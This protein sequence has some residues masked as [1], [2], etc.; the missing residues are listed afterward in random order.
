MAKAQPN[1]QA[2]AGERKLRKVTT[3]DNRQQA[4]E[5]VKVDEMRRDVACLACDKQSCLE[6]QTL[7]ADEPWRK[8]WQRKPKRLQRHLTI[9]SDFPSFTGRIH[10]WQ[11]G[12]TFDQIVA[13][14]AE[15]SHRLSWTISV[16][17][18]C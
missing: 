7:P 3:N 1:A 5:R 9:G 8:S 11:H 14:K 4:E 10:C 12:H 16:W 17:V 15:R 18:L 2:S 6:L 13:A